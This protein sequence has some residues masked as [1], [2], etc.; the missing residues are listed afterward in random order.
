MNIVS[1]GSYV[2]S[3]SSDA[4]TPGIKMKMEANPTNSQ[5][6]Q[7]ANAGMDKK[8]DMKCKNWTVDTSKFTIPTNITF[9]DVSGLTQQG[10]KKV[11]PTMPVNIP[12]VP[13]GY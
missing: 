12:T 8:M 6:N 4:K 7:Q 2:Y 9:T 5:A 11:I 10:S 3:W 13:A 1:D